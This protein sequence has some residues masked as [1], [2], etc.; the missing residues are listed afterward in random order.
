[1]TFV[2]TRYANGYQLVPTIIAVVDLGDRFD[3]E[4]PD[5][6]DSAG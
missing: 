1:M 5:A 6:N 2:V 3:S 4:N